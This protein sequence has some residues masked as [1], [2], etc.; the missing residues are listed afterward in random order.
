MIRRGSQIVGRATEKQ[1]RLMVFLCGVLC[2]WGYDGASRPDHTPPFREVRHISHLPAHVPMPE[3]GSGITIWA[4]LDARTDEYRRDVIPIFVMN[5]SREHFTLTAQD[6]FTYF[7]PEVLVDGQWKRTVP[8]RFSWC[9]ISYFRD[10]EI[11]K[12]SFSVETVP[13]STVGPQEATIRLVRRHGG[14]PPLASQTFIATIGLGEIETASLDAMAVRTEVDAETLVR[15]IEGAE[16][17]PY[18]LDLVRPAH[19]LGSRF[20]ER[21]LEY[22]DA[23][24]GEPIGDWNSPVLEAL[25]G[26]ILNANNEQ[27]QNWLLERV[28]DWP[29]SEGQR[30]SMLRNIA[31]SMARTM[32]AD[33]ARQLVADAWR[34]WDRAPGHVYDHTTIEAFESEYLHRFASLEDYRQSAIASMD[35][36]LVGL[37]IHHYVREKYGD[38]M[39]HRTEILHEFGSDAIP[40]IAECERYRLG[41]VVSNGQPGA[42][43]MVLGTFHLFG[44][45]ADEGIAVSWQAIELGMRTWGQDASQRFAPMLA[46]LNGSDHPGAPAA[47]NRLQSLLPPADAGLGGETE[48]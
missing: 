48:P 43:S 2:F 21:A 16:P 42:A 22:V 39:I 24:R 28:E 12:D 26:V 15:L 35:R 31:Q 3:P 4:D 17:R 45:S 18:V 29:L 30:E 7:F 33:Q 10:R 20:P 38:P 40:F 9:G 25:S 36:G 1:M 5:R 37:S 44:L 19:I 41:A 23:N 13:L 34:E 14:T 6:G 11:P 46:D 8:H 27:R 47:A 32:S